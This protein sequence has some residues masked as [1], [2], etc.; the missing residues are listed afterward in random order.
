MS[1]YVSKILLSHSEVACLLQ[2]HYP[3]PTGPRPSASLAGE[4]PLPITT[5]AGQGDLPRCGRG[6]APALPLL[7]AP[8]SP[9]HRA[10]PVQQHFISALLL[11]C[12]PGAG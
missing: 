6:G 3:V 1:N 8:L 10:L 4:V 2:C 9:G 12:Q 7:G 11:L 5:P